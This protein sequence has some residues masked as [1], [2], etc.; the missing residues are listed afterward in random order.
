MSSDLLFSEDK[1]VEAGFCA[2]EFLEGGGGDTLWVVT[3]LEQ[4]NRSC[5][6]THHEWAPQERAH[7]FIELK[8]PTTS[9]DTFAK[10]V[11]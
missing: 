4:T 5:N 6:M 3:T 2:G 11:P 9:P 1:Y 10:S 7:V 8:H